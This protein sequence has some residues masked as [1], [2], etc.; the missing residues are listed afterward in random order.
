MFKEELDL[1]KNL[2]PAQ[3]DENTQPASASVKQFTFILHRII[4]KI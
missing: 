3:I 4:G 1:G 2:M